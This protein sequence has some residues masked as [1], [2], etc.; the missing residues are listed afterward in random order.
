MIN[1]IVVPTDGSEHA[2]KAV[3]LAAD[4]AQKYAAKL[5]LAHALLRNAST[6]ELRDVQK[7]IPGTEHLSER[8]DQHDERLVEVVSTGAAGAYGPITLPVPDELLR[9]FADAIVARAEEV[10]MERGAT[11]F[12]AKI[13]DESPADFIL[14]VAED[15]HADMIVMG[16]RGLGKFADLLMGSVSHKVSHLSKCTCVTVK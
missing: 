12:E 1:V 5:V 13:S 16:S 15:E 10:S 11:I 6:A 7:S 4:L 14:Q 2:M 9:V 8:L 3:E